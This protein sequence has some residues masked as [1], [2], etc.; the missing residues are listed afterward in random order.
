MLVWCL[1]PCGIPCSVCEVVV[2]IYVVGE[3]ATT[4][5][6]TVLHVCMLREC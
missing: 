1:Q 2:V 3:V 6:V 4:A 5:A